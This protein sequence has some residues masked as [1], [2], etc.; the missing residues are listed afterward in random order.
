VTTT[1]ATSNSTGLNLSNIGVD[2]SG[3]VTFSGL[4]SGIDYQSLIANIIKAKH[5]PIDNL[6]TTIDDNTKKVTAYGDLKTLL[7]TLQNSLSQLRGA[8]SVD[9]S[10][11]V[12]QAKQ[13]FASTSRT[14]GAAPSSAT[15]LIGVTVTNAATVGSH[16]IEIQRLATAHKLTTQAFGSATTAL[17]LAGSFRMQLGTGTATTLTVSA[18]DTLQDVRDRINAANTGATASGISASI[19]TVG[20]S[21][22]YLVLTADKTAQ[23]IAFSSDTGGLMA[24]LGISNDGGVTL[25]N[26]I[27]AP[28]TAQ[29]YADGLLDPSKWDS[30]GFSSQTATLGTIA[31]VTAG[32]HS[33]NILDGTGAVV[34]TVT[35]SDT[36]T[37]QTLAAAITGGGAGIT[38]S[39]S[40]N[41]SG[42]YQLNIASNAGTA[43]SFGGDT[44]NLLSNLGATKERLLITRSSNTVSDLFN[45]VTLSL[46]GAEPGTAIKLEVDQNLTNVN[47]AITSFVTAYNAVR[48]FVNE[49]N[50]T[51]PSTGEKSAIAGPL[52]GSQT[53]AAISS[54]LA[55][56]LGN[57]TKGVNTAYSVLAQIGIKFVDN[58]T[59]S[60]PLDKDTLTIDSAKLQSALTSNPDDVRK[61]F[62]FDFSSSDSRVTLL[63]FSGKTTY[64]P[65]GYT[66]NLTHNGT[67]LT[68]ADING[69]ANS[70]TV[71]GHV[72][73][74]NSATGANGL[75]LY[76]SGSGNLSG[77]QIN[78]TVGAGAQMFFDLQSVLDSTS[79]SLQTEVN[80]LTS[81]NTQ[82]KTRIDTMQARLDYQ[83]QQL[84]LRFTAM[85]TQ[86]AQMSSI[87]DSIDQATSAWSNNNK[88]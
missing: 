15:D 13:A 72:I 6:Q 28:Q 23:T 32:S 38:G 35:Y 20:T 12:F 62:S 10:T 33:F 1:T 67:N 50:Q 71:N 21:Q 78:F 3:K 44:D 42:K 76:Y 30:V 17:G 24:G 83:Q 14:D 43:I 69:V 65:T 41:S 25:L 48:H 54:S 47:N 51:D 58:N 52:F 36:D 19:V 57:G 45:G 9:N 22:S 56:V 40:L 68:G 85:E 26:Q 27:Q 29:F 16:T 2:N 18:T 8:V 31:G 11:N 77:T 55:S 46:Y 60:D 82:T 86:L 74:V 75:K 34:Q 73:T 84:S 64:S 4:S 63:D 79:G 7:Q 70:A 5:V 37:L 61:M 59:L 49:Q 87:M 53:L 88:N 80:A 81:Q 39:V 66:L